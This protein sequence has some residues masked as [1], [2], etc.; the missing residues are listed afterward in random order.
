M[1]SSVMTMAFAD[2]VGWIKALDRAI[3]IRDLWLLEKS[4]TEPRA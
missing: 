3:E 4:S 1:G 2:P